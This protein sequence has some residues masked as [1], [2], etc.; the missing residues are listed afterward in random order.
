M[1]MIN[2]VSYQRQLGTFLVLF[3]LLFL[4]MG[5]LVFD[6]SLLALGN[7]LIIPGLVLLRGIAHCMKTITSPRGI[8]ATFCLFVG[9]I[10]TFHYRGWFV[11]PGMLVQIFGV[12]QFFGN[13]IGYIFGW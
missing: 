11:L 5:Y 12:I 6:T 4:F 8:G 13:F 1:F 2:K 10:L 9:I 3:A 7:V